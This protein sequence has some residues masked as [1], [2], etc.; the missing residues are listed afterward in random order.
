MKTRINWMSGI[1][2]LF[3]LCF[4]M[5][6]K[7]TG[8]ELIFNL[9]RNYKHD[10]YPTDDF[11]GALIVFLLPCI[12]PVVIM[13][14]NNAKDMTESIQIFVTRILIVLFILYLMILNGMA[15]PTTS[16]SDLYALGSGPGL[17]FSHM[18]NYEREDGIGLIFLM[19]LS[20]AYI[21]MARKKKD[22]TIPHVKR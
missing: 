22:P 1:I 17:A 19:F 15:D 6:G 12:I 10:F 14:I 8:I 4:R 7:Q 21:F 11:I 16:T 18:R 9:C 13:I 20:I 5:S 3:Y 2:I